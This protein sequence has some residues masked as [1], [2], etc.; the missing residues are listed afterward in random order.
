MKA[1]YPYIGRFSTFSFIGGIG[2]V[3]G[4][5]MQWALVEFVRTP[6][7]GAFTIQ[8]V[9]TI[10]LNYELNRRY[11]W[12]SRQQ[13]RW[14]MAQ[15]FGSRIITGVVAST[16]NM[17]LLLIPGVSYMVAAFMATALAMPLGYALVEFFIFKK[18]SEPV[19]VTES[20]PSKQLQEV[21]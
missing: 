8:L 7:V 11:T 5:A 4:L 19:L 3:V 20:T 12:R 1:L 6:V 9:F 18:T 10:W 15:F 13:N 2:F 14:Q 16:I 21:R 17:I